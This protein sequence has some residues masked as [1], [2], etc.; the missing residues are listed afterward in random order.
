MTASFQA[1]NIKVASQGL[2]IDLPDFCA[3]TRGSAIKG[4]YGVSLECC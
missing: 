1:S 2:A 4:V 3:G